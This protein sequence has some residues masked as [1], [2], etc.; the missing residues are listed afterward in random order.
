MRTTYR[1]LAYLI[2]AL[3]A[4]QSAVMVYAVAGLGKWVDDGGVL[5]SASMESEESL[6]TEDIGFF[7]HFLNGTLLI[8]LVA[9]V[10]VIVS[11]FARVPRGVVWALSVFG[12]VVLQVALGILGHGLT[13]FGL[14]HG[15]N[16]LVLFTVALV[17]A[18][19]ARSPAPGPA[20]AVAA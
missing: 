6:F 3:V 4:V 18:R 20:H 5:D 2:A 19:K 13:V 7:L 17:A 16:A 11:F 14:L 9:L 8:P 1:V 15:L 12:L 10:L